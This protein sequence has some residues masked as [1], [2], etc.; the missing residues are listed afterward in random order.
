MAVTSLEY[1]RQ[2]RIGVRY[3]RNRFSAREAAR[4]CALE[5]ERLDN[6]WMITVLSSRSHATGDRRL[7]FKQKIRLK[8]GPRY[9]RA[10]CTKYR[11]PEVCIHFLGFEDVED[12]DKEDQEVKDKDGTPSEDTEVND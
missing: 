10:Q 12:P 5:I 1:A 8:D 4:F 6:Y 7:V 2:N 11:I 9:A 3:R